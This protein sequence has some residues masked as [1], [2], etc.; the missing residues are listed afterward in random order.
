MPIVMHGSRRPA[1]WFEGHLL[2]SLVSASRVSSRMAWVCAQR[3]ISSWICNQPTARRRTFGGRQKRPSI[4]ATGA[5][6]LR[7]P[8]PL[9]RRVRMGLDLP[10]AT[11][12]A[13]GFPAEG[14]TARTPPRVRCTKSGVLEG[15]TS[16]YRSR[17]QCFAKDCHPWECAAYRQRLGGHHQPYRSR[18]EP[19]GACFRL[20]HAG[21]PDAT[22][23]TGA[24]SSVVQMAS[25]VLPQRPS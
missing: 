14:A 7:H 21:S 5:T 1:D 17:R 12:R 15:P 3:I 22:L 11:R 2:T 4:P 20:Q 19:A 18:H 8:R 25:S 13:R 24:V 10:T 6:C 23:L 9:C 16:Y